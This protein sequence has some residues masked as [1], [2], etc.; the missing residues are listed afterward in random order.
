MVNWTASDKPTGI[1][2]IAGNDVDHLFDLFEPWKRKEGKMK[3]YERR[4]TSVG[5]EL[6]K[7]NV[8]HVDFFSLDCEGCE[9]KAFQ[10]IDFTRVR[11]DVFVVEN[12]RIGMIAS[13][14]LETTMVTCLVLDRSYSTVFCFTQI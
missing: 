13:K 11:I 9:L 4:C 7:R 8:V 5:T 10:G 14:W 12:S 6:A 2:G 3:T 1:S